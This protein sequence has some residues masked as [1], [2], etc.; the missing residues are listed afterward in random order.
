[1]C[2]VC[3]W[4]QGGYDLVCDMEGCVGDSPEE[5]FILVWK[6][7]QDIFG[8]VGQRGISANHGTGNQQ[9]MCL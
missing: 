4:P 2:K 6:E 5:N 1:M 9:R 8:E 7:E 3:L